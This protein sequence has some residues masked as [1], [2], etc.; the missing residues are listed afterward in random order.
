MKKLYCKMMAGLLI[1]LLTGCS[2]ANKYKIARDFFAKRNYVAAI[3][4]YDLFLE[5]TEDGAMA[6]R[7]EVE[8]SESYYQLGWQAYQKESWLL[9]S[10]LFYLANS[11][12]A[13]EYLDNC[14][15]KLAERSF[16]EN[17]IAQTLEYY[18]N[19]ISYLPDSELLPEVIFKRI[20]I[21]VQLDEKENAFRDYDLLWTRFPES[22]F[23]AAIEPDIL[24]VISYRIGRAQHLKSKGDLEN[25]LTAYFELLQYPTSYQNKISKDIAEIYLL[26]AGDF[27]TRDEILEAREAYLAVIEYDSSRTG[28]VNRLMDNVCNTLLQQGKELEKELMIDEAITVYE[29]CF[30]LIPDYA[31]AVTAIENARDLRVR[32]ENALRFKEQAENIEYEKDFNGALRLYRQSYEQYRLPVVA[33]K[34]QEMNNLIRAEKDPKN[35]AIAVV[36]EY[37]NG[38]IVNAIT[39]IEQEMIANYGADIVSSSGW[40]ALYSSGDY[41][42]EVRYDILSPQENCY[43][44]WLVN[45]RDTSISPLNKMTESIM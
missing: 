31:A 9:A 22:E 27:I 20:K 44:I 5:K 19:I 34:I 24:P 37:K 26:L 1:T 30:V 11:I 16:A 41:K 40:K 6:T 38:R 4:Q 2:A 15:Y 18:G 7:A 25:S 45:L 14:Y 10:R 3:Q 8:R 23:I 28:E 36:K 13:D 32:Y 21:Y 42:Y 29:E 17:N 33:G 43:Y 12:Q 35:F 39:R